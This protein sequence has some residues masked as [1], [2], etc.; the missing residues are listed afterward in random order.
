MNDSE[1]ELIKNLQELD[2]TENEAKTVI[3]MVKI[4]NSAHATNISRIAGVPRSKIYSILNNLEDYGLIEMQKREGGTNYYEVFAIQKVLEIL[5]IKKEERLYNAIQLA[6]NNLENLHSTYEIE[7]E[8]KLDFVS[9][10]GKDRISD[11]ILDQ[12]S[13]I[14]ILESRTVL[15]LPVFTYKDLSITIAKKLSEFSMKSKKELPISIIINTEEYYE[16]KTHIDITSIKKYCIII[17]FSKFEN[18]SK[19][20]PSNKAESAQNFV[21]GNVRNLFAVRPLFSIVGSNS[22][23]IVINEK[24]T[25]NALKIQNKNFVDFQQIIVGYFMELIKNAGSK[26]LM[27]D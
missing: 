2:L 13:L 18:Q 3:A 5:K 27:Q 10:K 14:N 24:N 20:L 22:N 26:F 25:F 12:L 7:P 8:E 15:T 9:L 17:D 19:Q 16:L 6:K 11:Q 23:I 1:L 21:M 4:K